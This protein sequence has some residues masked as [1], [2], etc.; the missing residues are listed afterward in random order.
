MHTKV[1]SPILIVP[2]T[3]VTAK[4]DFTDKE[5][6]IELSFDVG[7][8]PAIKSVSTIIYFKIR[9]FAHYAR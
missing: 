2:E 1:I 6:H 3:K 4:K 8:E 9:V 5:K 7:S